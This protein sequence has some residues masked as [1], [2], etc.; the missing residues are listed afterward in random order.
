MTHRILINATDKPIEH[1]TSGQIILPGQSYAEPKE[2]VEKP[3]KA[4]KSGDE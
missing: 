4:K 2:A 1:P 3:E